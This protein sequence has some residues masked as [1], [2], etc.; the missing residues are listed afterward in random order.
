MPRHSDHTSK[1]DAQEE[2]DR[3]GL[4]PRRLG[5]GVVALS[6]QVKGKRPV[7]HLIAALADIDG[8]MQVSSS[9]DEHGLE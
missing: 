3:G 6:M 1:E 4:A 5:R 9:D 7:N 8:A 2:A